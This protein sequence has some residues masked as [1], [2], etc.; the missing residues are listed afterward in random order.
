M[1]VRSDITLDFTVTPRIAL[2]A[3]PSVALTVQ[4]MHD[5]LATIHARIYNLPF[6]VVI[7]SAGKEDIGGG[8]AVGI[9]G[10]LQNTKLKFADRG[11]PS[12]IQCQVSGGNTVAVDAAQ[13][14][15]DAI[16]PSTFTQVIIRQSTSPAL[17]S[18][19]ILRNTALANFQFVM[20]TTALTVTGT[21]VIDNGAEVAMDNSGSISE[22]GNN[23]YRIDLT[24]ADLNGRVIT[25]TFS[26]AGQS[27]TVITIIT[28]L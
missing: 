5:T 11:G 1:A 13:V 2:I 19:G 4:D 25:Y 15:L 28:A 14:A 12:T 23:K 3:A 21:R 22:I 17:I 16:E 10:T 27:D 8:E 7:L 18:Q 26:A 6:D 9:T 24:A 20:P